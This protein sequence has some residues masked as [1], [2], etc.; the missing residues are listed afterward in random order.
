MNPAEPKKLR[1]HK[2]ALGDLAEIVDRIAKDAPLRAERFAE[3]IF[4]RVERLSDMPYLGARCR[5]YPT[6]RQ[7]I[8]GSYLIYYT[9]HTERIVIRAVVHGARLFRP[10]WLER[11]E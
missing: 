9:V 5:Y 8:H 7:L 3:A 6:A 11:D 1:W 4:A 2:A 10:D